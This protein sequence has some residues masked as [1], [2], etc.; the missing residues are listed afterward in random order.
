MNDNF[1]SEEQ[2]QS[3]SSFYQTPAYTQG[4]SCFTSYTHS[5]WESIDA[6]EK[7]EK[8]I[9]RKI[10][11][12]T[13]FVASISLVSMTFFATLLY[14]MFY[15]FINRASIT[16]RGI[17][18]EAINSIASI[19]SL[20]ICGFIILAVTG[21][22]LYDAVSVR[23]NPS[24]RQNIDLFMV[25]LGI[26]PICNVISSFVASS[27]T[28]IGIENKEY[29]VIGGRPE[30]TVLYVL[31]QL[32][33][34]AIIP[35]LSEE[36][37]FRG[38]VLNVLKPYG[39]GFAIVMS[40][41]IFG[42]FH[43]NLGQ[44]PFALAGGMFFALLTLYSGSLIPSIL[45]HF[46]NNLLSVALDILKLGFGENV[47][48]VVTIISFASLSIISIIAFMR[49]TRC[50]KDFLHLRRPESKISGR[51]KVIS[52]LFSPGFIVFATFSIAET[53]LA[54]CKC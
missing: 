14:L 41:V 50:D 38:V 22:K 52:F 49:L 47:A 53:V 35:A 8:R 19:L 40:S 34:V 18:G 48:A 3:E 29:N 42:F 21:T 10:G 6:Q 27:L 32:L 54:Y 24:F 20:F 1:N 17:V 26:I 15:F 43:G 16:D 2:Q 9:M 4:N 25:G 51:Q 12:R 28:L 5:E 36:F 7:R 11:N 31:T 44:I 23:S 39:Q 30:I 45:L 33:C 13:G 37:F 46:F